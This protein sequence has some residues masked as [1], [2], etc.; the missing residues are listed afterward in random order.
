MAARRAEQAHWPGLT[1]SGARGKIDR[2][3]RAAAGPGG[4]FHFT[5]MGS[6]DMPADG[7]AETRAV[8]LGGFDRLL[9]D[10]VQHRRRQ[11]AAIVRDS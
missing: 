3:H 2:E 11:A 5:A 9:Q 6:G 7:H 1:A 4:D 8:G 10:A